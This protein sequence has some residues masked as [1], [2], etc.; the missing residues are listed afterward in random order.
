MKTLDI[1][2][3]YD[4]QFAAVPDGEEYSNFS[5][6]AALGAIKNLFPA[7]TIVGK[8]LGSTNHSKGIELGKLF[9][10]HHKPHAAPKPPQ[11]V[12]VRAP[13]SKIEKKDHT[14]MYMIGG[15]V[16]LLIIVLAFVL[17]HKK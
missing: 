15:G 5:I 9:G 8:A 12:V 10:G 17:T 1:D 13:V 14:K 2:Q 16:L 3:L 7:H 4:A 6:G 11:P